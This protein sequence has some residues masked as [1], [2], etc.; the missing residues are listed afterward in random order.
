MPLPT[1]KSLIQDDDV[2]FEALGVFKVGVDLGDKPTEAFRKA[3]ATVAM[4]AEGLPLTKPQPLRSHDERVALANT[5][6]RERVAPALPAKEGAILM[7]FETGN[8]NGLLTYISNCQREDCRTMLRK[9][10]AK[11]DEDAKS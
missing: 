1:L 5:L 7:L 8:V 2:L 4:R 9:L 11:W 6:M 10:L 3:M